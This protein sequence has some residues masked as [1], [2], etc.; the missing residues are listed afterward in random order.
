MYGG[1][2]MKEIKIAGINFQQWII[3][4]KNLAA[5]L[6]LTLYTYDQLHGMIDYAKFLGSPV[7]PYASFFTFDFRITVSH[8]ATE[9]RNPTHRETHMD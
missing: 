5:L 4:P 2:I 8:K 1:N 7:T 3:N 9:F 6:C